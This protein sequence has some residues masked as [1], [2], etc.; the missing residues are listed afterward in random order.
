MVSHTYKVYSEN[1]KKIIDNP[2]TL[3]VFLVGSSKDVDFSFYDL[4][5]NDIDVFVFVKEGEKQERVLFEQKGIEFDINYFSKDGVKKL[6][7]DRE[8]F[9][10]KEMKDAKVLF[11]MENISD[12]IKDISRDIYLKGPSK[13]SLEEKSFL[14]QDI[15]TKI[16]K[17]KNKEKF[18]VFEYHFL[19]NLYLKDIIIGYFNIND[20]WVPKD[21]KLLKVLK[22]E[23]NE[24]FN[25]VSKVS[26]NYDYQKLLDVYN[27]IFKEIETKKIIKL[28]F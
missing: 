23:N 28:I 5:I 21:K 22:K 10:V 8:Y 25:L 14:K 24:L 12:T 1:I 11:D 4:E 15:G 9:F 2:N 17:L 3:A 26:E 20:K 7:S 13:L 27:Y 16:S 6:L 18:D 19:T